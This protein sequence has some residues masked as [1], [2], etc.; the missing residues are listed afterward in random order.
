MASSIQATKHA[1]R[2]TIKHRLKQLSPAEVA[3]DSSKVVAHV[4]NSSWYQR[5]KTISCYLSTPFGEVD[6]D[7]IILD[8]LNNGKALFVPFC[9]IE[10]PT[11][12]RM[13]RLRSI[14][15]FQGLK[16]N[17]W[18]IRE[19]DPL[20]IDT[21]DDAETEA[22][23]GLDLILV[24][25]MAFDRSRKRL[26][27]GRGYYD[28]YINRAHET[29]EQRFGKPPPLSVALAL[30]AQMVESDEHIPWDTFD[31]KPDKLVLPS[32]VIE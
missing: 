30:N 16:L 19:L 31:R 3:Q 9:P 2:K 11:V 15:H 25:G 27:H 20:E 4:I 22:V 14:Q 8:A 32:G 26:G 7:P 17:R 23:G 5:A 29:Y 18:K 24:P 6:T 28:R 1:L 12:M 10:D 13:L 21:L